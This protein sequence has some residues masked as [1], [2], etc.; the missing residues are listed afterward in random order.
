[1]KISVTGLGKAGLPLAFVIADSGFEVIGIDIDEK[2]VELI[3]N[4]KNPIPE[5]PGLLELIKKYSGNKFIATTDGINGIKNTQF[6]IVI[7]PL[8]I[9][10]NNKPDFSIL[11]SAFETVGK[12]LKK[13]DVV[14]LETT[15]PV[16]TTNGLVRNILEKESNLKAGED[17]YLAYSPERIM[18]GYSISRYKEFPKI[19]G[20]INKISGEKALEVYNKFCSKVSLVSNE[21]T[22]E[23]IKISEGVYRDVNIALANELFKQCDYFGI[24]FE[25]MREGAKHPFCNILKAGIGVGGH[26]IPVYP[27]FLINEFESLNKR[28]FIELSKTGRKINDKMIDFWAEKI[29][30]KAK[31]LGKPINEIKICIKGLSYRKGVKETAYT[32]SIPL[33]RKLESLGVDVYAYDELYSKEEIEKMNLKYSNPEECDLVFDCFNSLSL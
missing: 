13:G 27:W 1:M 4:K 2:R 18:T 17:F 28:D 14:V 33:I 22:A 11:R 24:D 31:K 7:V 15:V 6:H 10:K 9:D 16:G 32:R 30:E 23:M 20:G 25:E 8:F 12:G 29:I 21:K 5:E 19:I 3:N 26:C